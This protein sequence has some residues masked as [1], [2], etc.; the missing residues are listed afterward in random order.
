MA[1]QRR[2][3]GNLVDLDTLSTLE[4]IKVLEART[5]CSVVVIHQ[6]GLSPEDGLPRKLFISQESHPGVSH[7]LELLGWATATLG[8]MARESSAQSE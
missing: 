2:P 7:P 4:L 8:E 3:R 6:R 1:K 5:D